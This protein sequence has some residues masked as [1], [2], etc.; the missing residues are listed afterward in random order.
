MFG[1]YMSVAW[2]LVADTIINAVAFDGVNY[3][4]GILSYPENNNGTGAIS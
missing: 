3:N 2:V 4:T 1:A